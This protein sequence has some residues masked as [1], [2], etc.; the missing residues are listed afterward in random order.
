MP[1]L[2]IKNIPDELY[3]E[4]KHV[5][6][7]HHR[8]IN[9]EVIMCLKRALFPRKISPEDRLSSIRALRAQIAPDLISQEEI[10]QAINEGRP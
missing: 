10:E 6:E 4:L 5:A 1:A 7:Q 8:S 9:S 3:H 2:T